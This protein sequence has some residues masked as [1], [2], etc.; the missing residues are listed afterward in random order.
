MNRDILFTILLVILCISYFCFNHKLSVSQNTKR[1]IILTLVILTFSALIYSA[2]NF[3]VIIVNA[4]S[5]ENEETVNSIGSFEK[6]ITSTL[7][8]ILMD[9][10]LLIYE[11]VNFCK[12]QFGIKNYRINFDALE[13]LDKGR[14]NN[15]SK[16]MI[17]ISLI[18]KET[19]LTDLYIIKPKTI[20]FQLCL[21]PNVLD[22]SFNEY[23]KINE[24]EQSECIFRS[25]I[26]DIRQVSDYETTVEN[27]SL[28]FTFSF[29]CELDIIQD[30]IKNNMD[31]N[32][33]NSVIVVMDYRILKTTG[34][35][36]KLF[37]QKCFV[38]KTKKAFY[39]FRR[40]IKIDSETFTI[41][42]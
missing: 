12:D 18:E 22:M 27:N 23:K 39:K 37:K 38:F 36:Y 14:V 9:F 40:N 20:C 33:R 13:L 10:I 1:F 16:N 8:P 11:T 6:T 17:K 3:I 25:L 21:Y 19:K 28:K 30:L 29:E 7:L 26:T 15:S 34:V 31:Y 24:S 41:I 4:V 5:T 35:L 2:K 32:D 42:H